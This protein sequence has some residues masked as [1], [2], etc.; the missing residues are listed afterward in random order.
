MTDT[1]AV[2]VTGAMVED[3]GPYR[4]ELSLNRRLLIFGLLLLNEFFYGW[5]WNTVDV[6]RP[7]FRQDLHLSLVQAGSAY[8]AQGA[9]ALTG[10]ILMGQF[11]DRFGR[12]N[13]LTIVIAGYALMLIA[14]VLVGSYPALLAQRVLLGFFAGAEFPVAVGI[15]VALFHDRTRGK[16]AGMLSASFSCSIILLGV[17]LG[18]FGQRDWH[19]LL[20][21]G[22]VPPLALAVLVF[23]IVPNQIDPAP[24]G[25][26]GRLPVRELFHP[27]LRRQ[28][29]LL[30]LMTG[31]NFFGYQAF[32]G[33]FTTYI[34][35]PRGLSPAI[36]GD[37]LAWQFA[38]NIAGSFLWGWLSDRLGRRFNALGLL[39]AAAAIVVFLLSPSNLVWLRLVG[40]VYGGTIC[41]SVIWGPWMAELYPVHLR[42]TAASIFNWGRIISFFAP[43]ITAAVA[44][45]FGMRAS[46]LLASVSFSLAGVIWLLQR[47]TLQR[48]RRTPTMAR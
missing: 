45:R 41:S 44:E 36:A 19:S 28:T 34:T 37:L 6:L 24:E 12:R 4:S 40:F 2:D 14:G 5:A 3:A 1:L 10:A 25:G 26:R 17:A 16:L 48:L 32:S 39:I 22:G 43:L 35:G 42:S 29:L 11:A 27:A 30:A 18:R 7:F 31:L 33:W 23:L 13:A 20:W 38:G 8:S 21:I 15:Y 9:G 47:E 46:M